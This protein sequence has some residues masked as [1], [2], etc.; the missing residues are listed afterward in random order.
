MWKGFSGRIR[1]EK[2]EFRESSESMPN[3][4][5][6]WYH[7]Y[8]FSVQEWMCAEREEMSKS[9]FLFD[10]EELALALI[11]IGFFQTSEISSE[12]LAAI[13]DILRFFQE[14][15]KQLILRFAYDRTGHGLEREPS[16]AR[17][18]KRHMEQLGAVIRAYRDHILVLQGIFVGNW[19]EMHGSK[20][21]TGHYPARLAETLFAVTE[22]CCYLAVRTP[23]WWRGIIGSPNTTIPEEKLALFNDGIF[24]SLTDLGTYSMLGRREA[25]ETNSWSRGE[26]L[27][28]QD[29]HM[30]GVPNGGEVLAGERL[31]SYVQA[32]EDMEK[33]HLS[34]LNS[35]YQPEQLDYWKKET[36]SR[37]DCWKGLSGYEYLG[38]H[39]GYRFVIRDLK[40]LSG[41]RLLIAV[42]NCGFAS[43]C[44][45]AECFLLVEEGSGQ[46]YSVRVDTDVRKWR[47]GKKIQLQVAIPHPEG[48]KGPGELFLELKRKRDGRI[49]RFANQ[50]A[51][52]RVSLGR[53]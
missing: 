41:G 23:S 18:V 8:Y 10:Q 24:G 47:S 3:P 16:S 44:E 28:W 12:G 5:C 52:E 4:G 43:L 6:G 37:P 25:G 9:I 34:Y 17:L 35:A 51:G 50:G 21:L 7:V 29:A 26:E 33:M 31:I 30:D 48:I 22:G 45:P 15:G 2:A 27:T 14:N 49:L 11:D 20:F 40:S 36:V 1:L 53:F 13:T 42:E 39:L 19:G 38:R 32:A 46:R